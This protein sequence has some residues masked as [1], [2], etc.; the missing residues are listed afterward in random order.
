MWIVENF[1]PFHPI[2]G[3]GKRYKIGTK[4]IWE[5]ADILPGGKIMFRFTTIDGKS[6][7][8][9]TMRE[10]D[11]FVEVSDEILQQLMEEY[12]KLQ[13]NKKDDTNKKEEEE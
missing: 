13:E 1:R 12:K 8:L 2:Y 11:Y 7:C 3:R 9:I 10:L 6:Q 5:V 4:F